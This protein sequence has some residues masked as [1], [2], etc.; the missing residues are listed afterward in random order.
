MDE[1]VITTSL[2]PPSPVDTITNNARAPCGFDRRRDHFAVAKKAPPK[3]LRMLGVFTVE[4]VDA[5]HY[6]VR[7]G[8]QIV[9]AHSDLAAALRYV[10]EAHADQIDAN[11]LL[12][13]Q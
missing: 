9:A 7:C 4:K 13:L 5:A 11:N 1:C 10:L 12:A 8:A 6:F 2:A 3:A